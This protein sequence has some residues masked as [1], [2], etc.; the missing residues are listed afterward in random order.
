MP[1]RKGE[2]VLST[3]RLLFFFA[4]FVSTV[5]LRLESP[6]PPDGVVVASPLEGGDANEEGRECAVDPASAFFA[7]F[8]ST[9]LLFV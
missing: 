3:R 6:S 2:S 8:V 1:M 5:L 9:V 7:R 4:R